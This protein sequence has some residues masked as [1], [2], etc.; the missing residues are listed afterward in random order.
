M[1]PD[2]VT[3]LTDTVA[4][5]ADRVGAKTATLARLHRA[6]LPVPD[7]VCLTA[8]AYRRQV[9]LAGLAETARQVIGAA[10]P[11]ARR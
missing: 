7:G 1:S 11:E 3:P 5:T 8:D 6:G 10:P 2:V 4:A 9:A